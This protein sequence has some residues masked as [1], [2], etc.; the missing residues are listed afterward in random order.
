MRTALADFRSSL[1]RVR[2]IADDND[3]NVSAILSDSALRNRC[4]S[5][6]CAA[7]VILSGF[8]ESFL[9]QLADKCIGAVSALNK[10]FASLPEKIQHSHYEFGGAALSRRAQDDRARRPSRIQATAHNIASRLASVAS[11]P[12]DV[13]WEAFAETH[14][15]PN[16]ETIAHYLKRFGVDRPWDR[17]AQKQKVTTSPL[18]L[19]T[20]LDSFVLLRH[21]CAHTGT[22]NTVPT[23]SELRE[24]CDLLDAIADAIVSVLED[25]VASL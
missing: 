21:E 19:Q 4:E 11:V 18:A 5:V 7:T 17:L 9:K 10:P 22:A 1:E 13:V 15:N 23:P 24:F 16:S 20:R 12:Y 3:K 6:R 14:S 25:H 8:L 2:D